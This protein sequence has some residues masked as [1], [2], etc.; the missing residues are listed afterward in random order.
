[1]VFWFQEMQQESLLLLL[2]I[3]H[4]FRKLN[5]FISPLYIYYYH[6]N[7]IHKFIKGFIVFYFSSLSNP[8]HYKR[9]EVLKN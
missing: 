5:I 7:Y 4:K 3:S 2:F 9:C 1:M 8:I 6:S